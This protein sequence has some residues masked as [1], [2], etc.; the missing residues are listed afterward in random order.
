MLIAKSVYMSR[1][2]KWVKVDIYKRKIFLKFFFK[3]CFIKSL[4]RTKKSSVSR[5]YLVNIAL[6]RLPRVSTR[7][8]INSRCV[9]SGRVWGVN[10]K[11]GLSRFELRKEVYK[12]NIPGFRRASW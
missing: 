6:T 9:I 10:S 12:S 5:R 2:D 3:K 7:T 1:H 8:Y 11:V 4:S